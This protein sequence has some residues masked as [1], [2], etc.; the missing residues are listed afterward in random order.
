MFLETLA[1]DIR[2]AFRVLVRTPAFALTAVFTLGAGLG[3]NA[4]LVT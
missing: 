4:M 3:V 2:F 1:Q